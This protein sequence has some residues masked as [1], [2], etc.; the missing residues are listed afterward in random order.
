M[1]GPQLL[2]KQGLKDTEEVLRGKK[3]VCLYFSAHWCPPC[4]GFT[5]VAA[6]KYSSVADRGEWEVVFLSS[7]Q[8]KQQFDSYY[9]DHPWVALPYEDRS[10]KEALSS[11]FGVRGIPTMVLLDGATGETKDG[12]CRSAVASA[13]DGAALLAQWA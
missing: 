11:Q 10:R 12:N 1:L 7:D 5:P 3:H 13:A 9:A 8:D 4:R 6:E 2:T